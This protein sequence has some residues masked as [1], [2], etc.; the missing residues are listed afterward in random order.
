MFS[1]HHPRSVGMSW[2]DGLTTLKYGA[3]AGLE[4][5][6]SED[7]GMRWI[8]SERMPSSFITPGTQAGTIPRSS[9]HSNM[10]LAFLIAG[11]F[12]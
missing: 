2:V 4:N 11:N 7:F 12:S 3:H 8:S 10:R 6:T 5:S 9:P 1:R